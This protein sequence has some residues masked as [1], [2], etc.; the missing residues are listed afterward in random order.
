MRSPTKLG[1]RAD[2]QTDVLRPS[3]SPSTSSLTMEVE[4]T[5]SDDNGTPGGW[6]CPVNG[7]RVSQEP[8][9]LGRIYRF[10]ERD[11]AGYEGRPV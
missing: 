9:R 7:V 4:S 3:S 11:A 1:T 10:V 5:L 2:L 8:R 6:R